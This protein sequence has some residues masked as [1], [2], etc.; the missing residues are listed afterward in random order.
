[1]LDI[2][3]DLNLMAYADF[4]IV[5]NCELT[6]NALYEALCQ[7][8]EAILQDVFHLGKVNVRAVLRSQNKYELLSYVYFTDVAYL[9]YLFQF[10]SKQNFKKAFRWTSNVLNLSS[11]IF[12]IE[13]F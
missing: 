3:D 8:N 5:D 9:T 6:T 12:F 13:N 7:H 10:G 1:V 2:L 4:Q 11:F